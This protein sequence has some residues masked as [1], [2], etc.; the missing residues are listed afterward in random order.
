MKL[1]DLAE[2]VIT[3]FRHY[4]ADCRG[5][6]TPKYYLSLGPY[7]IGESVKLSL[8]A[9][10]N[11]W[12]VSITLTEFYGQQ[13]RIKDVSKS[14]PVHRQRKGLMAEVVVYRGVT[15]DPARVIIGEPQLVTRVQAMSET[16]YVLCEQNQIVPMLLLYV[17]MQQNT[18]CETMTIDYIISTG[19]LHNFLNLSA[20]AAVP[21]ICP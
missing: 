10:N 3:D 11:L 21:T 4:I 13:K 20:S 1:D 18:T 6:K 7:T 5:V 19:H 17:M 16:G 2:S 8:G 14:F 15:G 9:L 12:M